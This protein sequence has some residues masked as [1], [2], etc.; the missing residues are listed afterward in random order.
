[1]NGMD[2]DTIASFHHYEYPLTG[3][4]FY[5]ELH[6]W[7][8]NIVLGHKCRSNLAYHRLA[9]QHEMDT[10][11]FWEKRSVPMINNSSEHLEG[12]QF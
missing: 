5:V 7:D 6:N 9:L 1:M 4:Y 2:L 10:R 8:K 3:T 11:Y 12:T